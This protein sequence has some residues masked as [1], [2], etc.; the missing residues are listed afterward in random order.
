MSAVTK[1]FRNLIEYFRTAS[2]RRKRRKKEKEE[3]PFIY[4]LF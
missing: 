2:E 3:N 1:A 4:P